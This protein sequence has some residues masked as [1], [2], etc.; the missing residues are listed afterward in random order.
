M[1][2][3]WLLCFCATT[4]LGRTVDLGGFWDFRYDADSRGEA[5]AWYS[6]DAG[7]AWTKIQ[8]P[9]SFD[10]ALR[11]N[12]QYQG[13]AWYR[14]WFEVTPAAGVSVLLRFDGVAIRS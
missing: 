9:G 14:T 1:P 2:R 12:V 8:V 7:P 5:G 4:L 3:I 11:N 13:K 6:S 10:Q